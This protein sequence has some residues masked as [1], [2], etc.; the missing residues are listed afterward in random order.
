MLKPCLKKTNKKTLKLDI[1]ETYL[2]IIKAV[3]DRPTANIILSGENLKGFPLRYGTQQG[4]PLLLNM[5]LEAT[6]R[7]IRQEKETKGI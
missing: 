7:T 3:H 4:C 5:V 2:N 1:E 6:A